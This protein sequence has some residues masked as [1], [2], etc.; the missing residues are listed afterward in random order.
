MSIACIN[1]GSNTKAWKKLP[2]HL[3]APAHRPLPHTGGAKPLAILTTANQDNPLSGNWPFTPRLVLP[4]GMQRCTPILGLDVWEHAYF[5]QCVF[6][7]GGRCCFACVSASQ[8]CSMSA[9]L[10]LDSRNCRIISAICIP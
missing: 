7:R 1:A 5:L 6:F 4:P 8:H 10:K 3:L 9:C 2:K